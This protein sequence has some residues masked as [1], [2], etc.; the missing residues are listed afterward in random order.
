LAELVGF[1]DKIG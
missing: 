1:A